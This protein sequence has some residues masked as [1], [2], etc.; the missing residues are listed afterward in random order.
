MAI[1]DEPHKEHGIHIGYMPASHTQGI[2]NLNNYNS[3]VTLLE[4][5]IQH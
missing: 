5:L 2:K 3:H 4:I 1:G